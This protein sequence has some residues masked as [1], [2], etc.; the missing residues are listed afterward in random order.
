[1]YTALAAFHTHCLECGNDTQRSVDHLFPKQRG[2]VS[3][4]YNYVVLCRSCNSRKGN[5]LPSEWLAGVVNKSADA[6]ALVDFTNRIHITGTIP[7]NQLRHAR[8]ALCN[9]TLKIHGAEIPNYYRC[10]VSSHQS[11]LQHR[12]EMC[13][14]GVVNN[15]RVI[16]NPMSPKLKVMAF[17]A[18]FCTK[19]QVLGAALPDKG[20]AL[21]A[22]DTQVVQQDKFLVRS[23]ASCYC[24]VVPVLE[25]NKKFYIH[26]QYVH[27]EF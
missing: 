16:R 11:M 18:D 21:I 17:N 6:V 19:A 14:V 24:E 5:K 22:P 26:E 20:R 3:D 15:H 1:M 10:F 9:P 12:E 23:I 7:I 2:G 8:C 27:K 25:P 4:L 13:V